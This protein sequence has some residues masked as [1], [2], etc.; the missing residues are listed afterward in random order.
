MIVDIDVPFVDTAAGQLRFAADAPVL[1]VLD[2]LELA[3]IVPGGHLSL[4]LLGAS[5]QAVL[6]MV[7]GVYAETVAC[8]PNQGGPVPEH[9]VRRVGSWRFDFR[10][11]LVT[12][13]GVEYRRRCGQLRDQAR[14]WPDTTLLGRFPGRQDALTYLNVSSRAGGSGSAWTSV[15]CYPESTTIVLTRTG[16][17]AVE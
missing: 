17:T 1:P 13:A 6:T 4:R 10:S 11:Q 14:Q 9:A 7:D 8:L 12:V 2:S 5:H 16:I 3:E 15:H